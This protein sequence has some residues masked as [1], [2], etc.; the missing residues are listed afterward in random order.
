MEL[1]KDTLKTDSCEKA[2]TS[3]QDGRWIIGWLDE[4]PDYKTQAESQEELQLN[5]LDILHELE[6]GVLDA[7]SKSRAR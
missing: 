2:C 4:H 3:F 7:N 1:R 5:L 6:S